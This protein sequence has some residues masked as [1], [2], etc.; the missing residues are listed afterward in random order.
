MLVV[1][2]DSAFLIALTMKSDQNHLQAQETWE[3]VTGQNYRFVTTTFVLDEVATL[4]RS[5]R[6]S[7]CRSYRRSITEKSCNRHD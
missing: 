6:A 1:F 5:K 3:H 4:E 7:T 2:L